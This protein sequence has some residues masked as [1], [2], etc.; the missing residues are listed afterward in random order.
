SRRLQNGKSARVVRLARGRT[1]A[2]SGETR[3]WR[4]SATRPGWSEEMRHAEDE[5]RGLGAGR[6]RI[7]VDVECVRGIGAIDDLDVA[8][9]DEAAQ[10]KV[11]GVAH[12]PLFASR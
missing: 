11:V 6:D 12:F 3:G 8:D 5:A 4:G 1:V 10:R 7:V 9:V 2:L